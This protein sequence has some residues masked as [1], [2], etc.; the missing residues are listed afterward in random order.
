[1]GRIAEEVAVNR[2]VTDGKEEKVLVSIRARTGGVKLGMSWTADSGVTRSLV[3]EK[4]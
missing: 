1:M 2:A 3:S 4:D